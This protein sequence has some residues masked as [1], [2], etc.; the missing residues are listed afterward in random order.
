MVT[1]P[2]DTTVEALVLPDND[3]SIVLSSTLPKTVA[4]NVSF[5]PFT[6]CF[7]SADTSRPVTIFS[8]DGIPNEILN[9][10]P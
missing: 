2:F 10:T 9:S 6:I 4:V 1:T 8:V 3:Q 5:S 7:S